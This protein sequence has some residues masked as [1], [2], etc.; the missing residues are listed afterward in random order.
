MTDDLTEVEKEELKKYKKNPRRVEA[1]RKAGL[2]SSK[3]SNKGR[4]VKGD[5]ANV[6]RGKLSACMNTKTR[7][8]LGDDRASAC[9]KKG[10]SKQLEGKK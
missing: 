6:L 4:F 2:A 8:K 10:R 1:A 9:G 5:S 3:L 7:F